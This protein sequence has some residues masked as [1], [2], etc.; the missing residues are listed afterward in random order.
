M[1]GGLVAHMQTRHAVLV[2]YILNGYLCVQHKE[3]VDKILILKIT[4]KK[5]V[6]LFVFQCM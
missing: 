5:L 3:H 1:P 4:V 2:W 6:L